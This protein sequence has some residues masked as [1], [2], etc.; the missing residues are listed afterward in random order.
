MPTTDDEFVKWGLVA[1]MTLLG[2]T[3]DE[4]RKVGEEMLGDVKEEK[5]RQQ[6]IEM[7]KEYLEPRRASEQGN[8]TQG[9]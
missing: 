9:T 8:A 7:G 4:A 1:G 3:G 2:Q 5:D 6:L